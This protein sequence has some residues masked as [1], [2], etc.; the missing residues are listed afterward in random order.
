MTKKFPV[1][2]KCRE[3]L[4][5]QKPTSTF[6]IRRGFGDKE[7]KRKAI[8]SK[9]R[10]TL[11]SSFSFCLF[12]LSFFGGRNDAC[13]RFFPWK[14]KVS[15]RLEPTGHSGTLHTK[16]RSSFGSLSVDRVR[17]WGK[18]LP[19]IIITVPGQK[20]EA[21]FA[22]QRTCWR[23]RRCISRLCFKVDLLIFLFPFFHH[24]NK[25]RETKKSGPSQYTTTTTTRTSFSLVHICRI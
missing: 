12:S 24:N 17:F 13:N 23:R 1:V 25:K 20:G 9:G 21:T 22:L 3:I 19:V 14:R 10:S 2:A 5:S 6:L 16:N 15:S 7:R 8:M 4:R 11:T 18:F